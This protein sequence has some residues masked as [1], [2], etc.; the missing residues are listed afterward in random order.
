[1]SNDAMAADWQCVGVAQ[2]GA[3]VIVAGG[4]YCFEFRSSSANVRAKFLFIGGGLGAGGS[5]GGGMSPSPL[6]FATNTIPDIWTSLE[7][8]RPFSANELDKA[9]AALTTLGAAFALGYS[10]MSITGGWVDP[11]FTAQNVSGWGTGVGAGGAMMP[12]IWL[13]LDS[14][15]YY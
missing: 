14:T 10:L 5:L 4:I 13:M 12:G 8:R 6:D 9:Y 11:L 2:V 15:D 1:M 7:C 3:A